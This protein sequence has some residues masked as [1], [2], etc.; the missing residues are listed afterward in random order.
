MQWRLESFTPSLTA[1]ALLLIPLSC[2][3]PHNAACD[4][5]LFSRDWLGIF[6]TLSVLQSVSTRA[7]PQRYIRQIQWPTA[8]PTPAD[9]PGPPAPE[10]YQHLAAPAPSWSTAAR[11]TTTKKP[12]RLKGV[13]AP[14]PSATI[15]LWQGTAAHEG[16]VT[17]LP[18]G[19]CSR[20]GPEKDADVS[21]GAGGTERLRLRQKPCASR[22]DSATFIIM[23]PFPY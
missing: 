15:Y 22:I 17:Q 8:L 21:E 4:K 6:W 16:R 20:R 23:L 5:Q 1:C 12:H 9:Q 19:N 10:G 2:P 3:S 18:C 13:G 7:A 11:H 14:G